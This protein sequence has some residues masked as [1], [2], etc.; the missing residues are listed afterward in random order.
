VPKVDFVTDIGHVT[1]EGTRAELGYT[2]GGPEWLITELGVFDYG[3][4]GYARLR[5]VF[6]DV[7]LA[8]VEAATGF[9]LRVDLAPSMLHPPSGAELAAVRTL[10]PLGV[11][12]L[13]FSP[14]ECKRHFSPST[15]GACA[16]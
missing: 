5:A 16:C 12:R 6:P 13:E 1:P 4:D 3:P 15:H 2:G 11:R 8:D 10:D 7:E 14:E 9:E